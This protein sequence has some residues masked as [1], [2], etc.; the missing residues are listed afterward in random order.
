M[1]WQGRQ[2]RGERN[3]RCFAETRKEETAL[4]PHGEK[5]KGTEDFVVAKFIA[6]VN[7]S[8]TAIETTY[9]AGRMP[10]ELIQTKASARV[11]QVIL[12]PYISGLQLSG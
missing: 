12:D 2:H 7:G 9:G 5:S 10:D 6:R 3:P 11:L 8:D 1:R 4:G